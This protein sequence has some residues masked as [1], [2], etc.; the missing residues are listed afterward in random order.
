MMF[1]Q[2]GIG[3]RSCIGIITLICFLSLYLFY[4]LGGDHVEISNQLEKLQKELTKLNDQLG[5]VPSGHG[6]VNDANAVSLLS[7]CH[8]AYNVRFTNMLNLQKAVAECNGRIHAKPV[9]GTI[10]TISEMLF[11]DQ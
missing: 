1:V 6:H 2:L 9:D 11:L 7:V 4:F 8:L 10:P 3:V 5:K